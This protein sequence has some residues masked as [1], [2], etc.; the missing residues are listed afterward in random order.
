MSEGEPTI[1]EALM[2]LVEAIN[3]VEEMA[4]GLRDRFVEN[5]WSKGAAEHMAV[6]VFTKTIKGGE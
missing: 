4:R 6:A 3:P 2:E 5:G 1:G